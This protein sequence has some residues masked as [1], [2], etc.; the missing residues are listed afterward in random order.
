M[1]G[2]R[3]VLGAVFSGGILGCRDARGCA[4]W[5]AVWGNVVLTGR[6]CCVEGY[7]GCFALYCAAGDALGTVLYGGMYGVLWLAG[8]APEGC[9]AW[10]DMWDAL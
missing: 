10:R 1:L 5:G 9:A 7:A 2:C 4:L 8:D 3:G 6:S